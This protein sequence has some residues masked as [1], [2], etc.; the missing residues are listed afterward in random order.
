[1][2]AP[3]LEEARHLPQDYPTSDYWHALA[4]NR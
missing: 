3:D 2:H 1:M 4:A